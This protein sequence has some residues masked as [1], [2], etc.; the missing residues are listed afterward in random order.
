MINPKKIKILLS[1]IEMEKVLKKKAKAI[2][3][4][5]GKIKEVKIKVIKEY[6]D[7][8]SFSLVA[9]YHFGKKKIIGVANSDGKKEYAFRA[10]VLAFNHLSKIKPKKYFTPRP[11]CYIESLGLFLEEFLEGDNFGKIL[12]EGKK[13]KDVQIKRIAELLFFLQKTKVSSSKIK[14]GIDFYDIEKNIEILKKRREEKL[15]EESFSKIKK[16]IRKY[17]KENKAKVFTHGDLNPY[18]LFFD[19]DRVKIID[20][21]SAHIG[22]RVSDLANIFAHLETT[23]DFQASKKKFIKENFLGNYQEIAGR[24]DSQEKEKFKTYKDYF[25]LL[26]VSHVLVWGGNPQKDKVLKIFKKLL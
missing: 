8:R 12:K 10:N 20:Y 17:E 22:D 15:I 26:N 21:T 16:K 19:K 4:P 9:L 18:N 2:G 1:P 6:I 25:N 13:I 3:I 14:V 23:I 7:W 11:Y 5:L 24:F